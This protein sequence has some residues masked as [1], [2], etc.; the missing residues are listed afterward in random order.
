MSYNF[1]GKPKSYFQVSAKVCH[2][3]GHREHDKELTYLAFFSCKELNKNWKKKKKKRNGT[4]VSMCNLWKTLLLTQL[5]VDLVDADLCKGIRI[6]KFICWSKLAIMNKWIE[7]RIQ[8]NSKI[9]QFW[10]FAT[11]LTQ[12]ICVGSNLLNSH[13]TDL[14]NELWSTH[15]T[16]WW[17]LSRRDSKHL[18]GQD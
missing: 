13:I 11:K 16:G 7:W 1:S 12:Q 9:Y 2:K 5:L 17:H 10:Q 14:D 8:T 15:K 18:G 4:I 3:S 6:Q